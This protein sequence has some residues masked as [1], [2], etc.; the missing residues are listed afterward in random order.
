MYNKYN[1]MRENQDSNMG[2]LNLWS[3]APRT[4]LSG[5]DIQTDQTVTL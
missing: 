2:P 3:G 5:A 4:K 1:G